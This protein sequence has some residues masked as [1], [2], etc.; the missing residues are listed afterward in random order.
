[1]IYIGVDH[2]GLA[3]PISP[4]RPE[5]TDALGDRPMLLCLGTDFRHKNRVFAI[6]LLEALRSEQNWNGALVLAG[7]RVSYGSS[8]GEEAAYLATRPDLAGSV[9][10]LPAVN[11]A[12]KRWLIERSTAMLYPT[13][14]EGFGLMPFEAAAHGRPCLFAA[15][16]ALAE[17]LPYELATLVPWNPSAS[18]ER[19]SHLLRV[20]DAAAAQV[21]AIREAGNRYTWKSTGESLVD[22]YFATAASPARDAARMAADLAQI[23]YDREESERKYNELWKGLTPNMR[24]IVTTNQSLSPSAAHSLAMLVRRPMLRRL[25]LGPLQLAHRLRG[26]V[27]EEHDA[28]ALTPPTPSETVALHFAGPNLEHMRAQLAQVDPEHLIPEP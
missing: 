11:E 13:T 5:Q 19:V 18:A 12:E 16:T 21:R 8:A 20:P 23:E 15:Q 24:S 3:G 1:V 2:A 4:Q 22:T 10:T 6:R 14:Y 26:D 7:P 9:V 25:V 27:Q 28:D 17:T